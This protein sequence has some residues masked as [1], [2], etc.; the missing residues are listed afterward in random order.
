MLFCESRS[1]YCFRNKRPTENIAT[2]VNKAEF[3]KPGT[4]IDLFKTRKIR[5]CSVIMAF[6]WMFCAHAYFGVSQYIGLLQGN[7]YINVMLTGLCLSPGLIF[8][9]IATL[10]FG[11]KISVMSSF[12]LASVSLLIFIPYNMP[13]ATLAFA[14]IGQIGAYTAFIQIYLYSSEIFPTVIRNSAL[15]FASVF[16]RLGGFFAPFVINIG[17]NWVSILIFSSLAF[18]AGI[19]CSFL[20]ETKI[21]SYL[22]H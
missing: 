6:V 18:C 15:G 11:R 5:F 14:I 20:P 9:L 16:A 2:D 13:S 19:L 22:I 8:V 1:I 17:I 4:C 7:L 10:Y 12:I 3:E 21:L